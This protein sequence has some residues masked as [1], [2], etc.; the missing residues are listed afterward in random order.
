MTIYDEKCTRSE[1]LQRRL[2]VDDVHVKI[3]LESVK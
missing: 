1:E 2:W 3:T